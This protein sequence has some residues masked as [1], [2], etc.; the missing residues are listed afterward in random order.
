ML[1]DEFTKLKEY[2]PPQEYI[3]DLA[4]K[5]LLTPEVTRLWLEHLHTVLINRIRGAKK[6]AAASRAKAKKSTT[7][8]AQSAP[9]CPQSEATV[10]T[11]TQSEAAETT[12][13]LSEATETLPPYY[14]LM[15]Q[16]ICTRPLS[17]STENTHSQSETACQQS[18]ATEMY[19]CGTCAKEYKEQTDNEELWIGCDLC[20]L[21]YCGSCE[22]LETAPEIDVY[23]CIKCGQ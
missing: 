19:Q 11:R 13:P 8:T 20:E 14:S 6:A 23:L 15:P 9:T 3:T 21:W 17:E 22:G 2:P 16:G 12:R 7:A 18:A 4:P 5:V 10:T 1:K